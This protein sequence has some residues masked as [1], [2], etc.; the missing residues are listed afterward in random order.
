[1]RAVVLARGLA[2]RMRASAPGIELASSQQAAAA[3][4]RKAMM[5]VG[6]ASGAGRPFLDYV[7]GSLADAGYRE[8]AIVIGPEHDDV[9]RRYTRDVAC[10]R[11]SVEFV[12]QAEALGTAHAVLQVEAWAD[13][14][15]FSV[16]NADNLYPV[17]VLATL[18]RLSSAGLPVFRRDELVQSS[19]FPME[20][21]ASFALVEVDP[22]GR[23]TRIVE[24]P[25]PEVA[26]AAGPSGLV[27]M[28]CWR[29]DREIFAA[30]RE[31]PRSVRGEF[32]LPEAVG[33]AVS[34]GVPFAAFPA[35][36]AVLD[37]SHRADIAG[38]ERRLAGVEP[39]L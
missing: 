12:V 3:A 20:R 13:G 24:K 28:N 7:L 9:R 11:L 30:C 6:G 38:V 1:M 29:F 22:G 26:A 18:G 15:P 35:S 2:R 34:R 36:G 19:G 25:G 32:E 33:L 23:L 27:S 37:L 8:T 39:R 4:G 5:P 10:A 17:E 16:V 21:I 31:V 14:R